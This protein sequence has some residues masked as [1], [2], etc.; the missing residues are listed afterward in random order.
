MSDAKDPL[1]RGCSL[2]TEYL[3]DGQ[4]Q[5]AKSITCECSGSAARTNRR[6]VRS[7]AEAGQTAEAEAEA[8]R[9]GVA[10]N[11]RKYSKS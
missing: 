5:V 8:K 10:G 1:K 9:L 6:D 2:K 3:I 7:E 11:V 4:L